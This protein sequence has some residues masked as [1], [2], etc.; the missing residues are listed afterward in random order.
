M[1]G[2][3]SVTECLYLL[4]EPSSVSLYFSE[5][6]DITALSI[7]HI[8]IKWLFFITEWSHR[9]AAYKRLVWQEFK[10]GGELDRLVGSLHHFFLVVVLDGLNVLKHSSWSVTTTVTWPEGV[11]HRSWWKEVHFS[12]G[13]A[14][15]AVFSVWPQ[16]PEWPVPYGRVSWRAAPLWGV[17]LTTAE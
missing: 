4:F 14:G 15:E 1:W 10:L 13:E 7:V 11:I 8:L 2:D 5:L 16:C 3:A 6:L 9:A 17:I 12:L